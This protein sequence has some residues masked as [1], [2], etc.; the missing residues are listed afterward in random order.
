MLPVLQIGPLA[1][2]L[3]G[4]LLLAGVWFALLAAERGALRRAI[5]AERMTNMILISLVAG[6]LGARLGYALRFIELYLEQP[7]ALFALNL[8]TLS[9]FE[10]FI[11]AILAGVI[12]IQRWRLPVLDVL[13]ALAPGLALF[14]IAIGLAHLAS[15]DAFGAVSSV[16]WSIELWGA[17][18]QPSQVYEI[19][20]AVLI[21]GFI[22][23]LQQHTFSPGFL[24]FALLTC[25]SLARLFL[26]AF[27][28]D[29]LIVAGSLRMGQVLSLA[30]LA[31]SLLALHLLS[32][33]TPMSQARLER[34]RL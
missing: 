30:V 3:P 32:R 6:I 1:I 20:A 25:H 17:E 15:G 10:G 28:G 21:Y 29:S 12:C 33:R 8:N 23:R 34:D 18:R 24:F 11:A 13:D 26:E 16:P 31:S 27:R 19:I 7:L 9:N 22:L 2:Q 4:V 5:P 14:M